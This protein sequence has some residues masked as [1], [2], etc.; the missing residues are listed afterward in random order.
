MLREHLSSENFAACC[1]LETRL[2]DLVEFDIT[3][4]RQRDALKKLLYVY[5]ISINFLSNP[6]IFCKYKIFLIHFFKHFVKMGNIHFKL[7]YFI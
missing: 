3:C 2:N 6:K 4:C 7:E 5:S 1:L